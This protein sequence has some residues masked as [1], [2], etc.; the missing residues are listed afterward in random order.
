MKFK[1]ILIKPSKKNEYASLRGEING[2]IVSGYYTYY[3]IQPV[4][5]P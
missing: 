3:T 1:L 2:R 5:Y 4:S